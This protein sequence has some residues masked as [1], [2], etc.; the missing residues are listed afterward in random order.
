MQEQ[1]KYRAF[2]SYRHTYPDKPVAIALQQ[3]LEHYKV[4]SYLQKQGFP[5]E[6]G[7]IFR[8]EADLPTSS[9]LDNQIKNALDNSEYLI[10]ICSVNAPLSKYVSA[11]IDY[12]K[13]TKGDAK[14][15]ALLVSG[16]PSTEKV[17]PDELLKKYFPHKEEFE[18]IEPIAADVRADTLKASLK[19]LK[20]AKLKI[21]AGLLGCNYDDLV[22]R[23]REYRLTRITM[24]S[25]IAA[26][27]FICFG[28]FLL[29]QLY[30]VNENQRKTQLAY[31]ELSLNS[32]NHVIAMEQA[33]TAMQ[34]NNPLFSKDIP[35]DTKDSLFKAS[36]TS[37]FSLYTQ[38]PLTDQLANGT[39]TL[40]GKQIIVKSDLWIRAYNLNGK[41]LWEFTA[42]GRGDRIV[43][44]SPDGSRAAIIKTD[45]R[46]K[47]PTAIYLWD[48]QNKSCI[49]QLA[50]SANYSVQDVLQSDFSN[51]LDAKF[52]PD[53]K[54]VCAYKSGGYFNEND[55]IQFWN[56]STGD[57]ESSIDGALLGMRKDGGQ[58]SIVS[59]G[60]YFKNGVIR[61]KGSKNYVFFRP[62]WKQPV[63]MP[64][65]E[66]SFNDY[67]N[68]STDERYGVY[69]D[70]AK[71][72]RIKDRA[73]QRYYQF[74][75]KDGKNIDAGKI[76]FVDQKYAVVPVTAGEGIAKRYVGIEV[77][78]VETMKISGSYTF[79]DVSA[80]EF[81]DLTLLTKDGSDHVYI[82]GI[83]NSNKLNN[84]TFEEDC[85]TLWVLN[86][87]Q[88]DFRILSEDLYYLNEGSWNTG[89]LS[90]GDKDFLVSQRTDKDG[91][92]KVL[93][94]N[95]EDK[96]IQNLYHIS[97]GEEFN[98]QDAQ[99]NAEGNCLLA[100]GNSALLIYS[101]NNRPNAVIK[102]HCEA[103]AE[104]ADSDYTAA[105]DEG[106]IKVW[107]NNEVQNQLKLNERQ[108]S[109]YM[110]QNGD[111][112]LGLNDKN[113]IILWN[114]W[115]LIERCRIELK[116]GQCREISIS[117]DGSMI[118]VIE[119]SSLVLYSSES[120]RVIR[121]LTDKADT[122]YPID[123]WSEKM[124]FSPDGSQI[125][126][127]TRHFPKGSEDYTR[128]VELW[129]A[130]TG[131]NTGIIPTIYAEKKDSLSYGAEN[132]DDLPSSTESVFFSQDGTK[133]C[134]SISGMLW[135]WDIKTRMQICFVQEEAAP[136]NLPCVFE[137]DNLLIYSTKGAVHIWNLK[138]CQKEKVLTVEGGLM[139]YAVSPEK[140]WLLG[141]GQEGVWLFDLKTG[142]CT[143]K[144]LN[145]R[146]FSLK[147]VNK[148]EFLSY[149]SLV[150][151]HINHVPY[152]YNKPG[153]ICQRWLNNK[154]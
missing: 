33:I 7:H 109:L 69:I 132:M 42:A 72:F 19:K 8:D 153:E 20:T 90:G 98:A 47:P 25:S 17:F 152:L 128:V 143:A 26:V 84:S 44:V 81:K 24:F 104:G 102:E 74:T 30:I 45:F 137:K 119:G 5:S 38:I 92:I 27:F 95:P 51:V 58:G 146:V 154:E 70:E 116:Q 32:G 105:F 88:K 131:E 15:L 53:G 149:Y 121:T 67:I 136:Q 10:V 37:A 22:L 110:S 13:K 40:N 85:S 134:T 18:Q 55:V 4:P 31:S 120:G 6:L 82:L 68:I 63:V 64:L 103:F 151:A 125:A 36:L 75:K 39:F 59:E 135:I 56:A 117:P 3:Q 89:S 12:F 54:Y 14:C 124:A 34:K 96:E 148:G 147:W 76:K 101:L 9:D 130:Y 129:D 126:C 49:T 138:T 97:N 29:R 112:L 144:V 99:I 62:D 43:A 141:S 87:S 35:Q 80:K 23:Q 118:A 113:E 133:I 65:N 50:G 108:L 46:K 142:E 114:T 41:L 106:A 145:E 52:S 91:N 78:D 11:E 140:R 127:V 122:L 93:E 2:I 115:N 83:D 66:A 79:S 86:F 1:R 21:V 60:Q 61:F 71:E 100:K 48:T 139:D 57:L 16:D 123:S 150:S 94:I 111:I 73:S 107:K 77:I 28:L